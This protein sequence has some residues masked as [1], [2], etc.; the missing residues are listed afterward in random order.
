MHS[1]SY[2]P[3]RRYET[4]EGRS[5][6]RLQVESGI[7]VMVSALAF[8]DIFL[9]IVA[10]TTKLV[11]TFLAIDLVEVGT[12]TLCHVWQGDKYIQCSRALLE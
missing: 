10:Q 3:N 1:G 9:V 12:V 8:G 11:G 4:Q 5:Q 7:Q 2:E 6:A